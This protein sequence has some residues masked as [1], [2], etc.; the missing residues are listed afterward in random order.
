[1]H[2]NKC[3]SKETETLKCSNCKQN[4]SIKC[5]ACGN[6]YCSDKY[7]EIV[8]LHDKRKQLSRIAIV[9]FALI[10]CTVPST[11]AVMSG[12]VRKVTGQPEPAQQPPPPANP[13]PPASSPAT[14]TAAVPPA[15]GGATPTAQQATAPVPPAPPLP[16]AAPVPGGPPPAPPAAVPAPPPATVPPPPAVAAAGPLTVDQQW[17]S[18]ASLIESSIG[19]PY[20]KECSSP[21]EGG[22]DAPGYIQWILGQSGHPEVTRDYG[23]LS[24][25]GVAVDGTD[26]KPGDILLFSIKKDGNVNFAG[27]YWKEKKFVYPFPKNQQVIEGDFTNDFFKQRYVGARRVVK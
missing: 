17:A 19:T 14:P 24:K 1:M 10:L 25:V 23:V 20:R 5:K 16:T 6:Q 13:Q 26:Y 18:L 21:K 27:L 4:A 22:V 9:L 7:C 2:C 12:T 15:P 3:G 8:A 11:M